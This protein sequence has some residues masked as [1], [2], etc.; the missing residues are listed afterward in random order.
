MKRIPKPSK[1]H[2]EQMY[3]E[4]R[5]SPYEIA[6]KY[7]VV[8]ATI[9]RWLK[10]YKIPMRSRSEAML[11]GSV[12]PSKE[13]LEIMYLDEWMHPYEIG[14]KIGVGKTII[15]MWLREYEIPIRNRSEAQFKEEV[16]KPS[17]EELEIMYLD[18]WMHPYEIGEKIGVSVVPIRRWLRE[19][20]IPI[21]SN[22]AFTGEKSSG[23]NG[24]ISYLP[25]CPKFNKSLK[26][27][28]RNRDERVCQ[29]CG[30]K[31]N[32][33]RQSVHHIH[34]DKE[35]CYP[36][37]ITVCGS[38]NT[39]ANSDRDKWEIFYMNKLNDRGLLNWTSHNATM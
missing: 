22:S 23:W 35:N 26:E 34:Y 30:V 2:L 27:K 37:L 33:K 32:G 39:K 38:C 25:Y 36:D 20:G 11:K 7:G 15:G 1:E 12:K 13:E 14:E 9:R 8:H 31:E 29:N 16:I 6:E 18:E 21:R 4:E 24:G 28:I 3:L 5:I 19:Y 17:K 10:S